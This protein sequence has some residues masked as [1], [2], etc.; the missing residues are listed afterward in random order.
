MLGACG[1][2]IARTAGLLGINRTTL[3]KKIKKYGL[4]QPVS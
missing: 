4:K 1:W 3:Y 2:N